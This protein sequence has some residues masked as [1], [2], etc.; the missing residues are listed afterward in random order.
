MVEPVST[1]KLI[2]TAA[3]QQAVSTIQQ[4]AQA[5]AQARVQRQQQE[6]QIAIREQERAVQEKRQ[7][8]QARLQ[9]AKARASFGARGVSSASGSANA[10]VDGIDQ[11]TEQAIAEDRQLFDLG[12]ENL[13]ANQ[14]AREKE[15]LLQTRNQ[16]F[17]TV[18]N[19]AGKLMA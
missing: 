6:Q 9:Q 15:S 19:T 5:K 1:T 11:R 7:R 18:V 17:S 4:A 12:V 3:A 13:R 8:E 10:L 2:M 14:S 16:I